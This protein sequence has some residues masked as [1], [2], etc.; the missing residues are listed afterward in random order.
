MI[1]DVHA[2]VYAF[3]KI[4]YSN[5]TT[6]M[7]I[8]DQIAVMDAKGIDMAVV[9]PLNDA[10]SPYEKQ[11]IGEILYIC[12]KYPKRF[13]P[14]C[15][16]DPRLDRKP[17][18]ITVEDFLFWLRQYKEFG[19]KGLGELT[20]R[21][22]WDEPSML[23]LLEACDIVGFPITFHTIT[24]D[25]NSYGVLDNIGLS[26]L[27]KV[28]RRFPNLKFFGHSQGFWSEISGG[29]TPQEKNA[30]PKTPVK[31]G[32]A[33]VRLMRQYP[34]LYGDISAGSGLNALTRD[35]E[36]AYRFIDEFQ[37]KLMLGLDYCSNK[38]NL[39]HVEWLTSAR[40]AGKISNM[41]FEKIT[42]KNTNRLLNLGL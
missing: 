30:Y 5:G 11:S 4:R 39:T 16:I 24:E 20:A 15:N 25:V 17:D 3:P 19:C 9:L 41:A 31:P 40:N 22:S 12:E 13:I 28:L 34:N 37:D 6:F 26:G 23:K 1:I 38:A 35:P 18:M 27:E 29:I 32:G 8:E 14:F 36:H 21:M 33:V 2:H 42:W 7:S 10:E